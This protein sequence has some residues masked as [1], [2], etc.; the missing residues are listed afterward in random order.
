MSP[1]SRVN[2]VE[3]SAYIQE[4]DTTQI[5]AGRDLQ[6]QEQIRFPGR[7]Y[8]SYVISGSQTEI[9]YEDVLIDTTDFIQGSLVSSLVFSAKIGNIADHPVIT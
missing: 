5:P 4:C 3:K 6:I 7:D 1:I 8:V 2:K 9:E